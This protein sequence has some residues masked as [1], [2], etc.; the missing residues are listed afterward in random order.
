MAYTNISET[1]LHTERS[2]SH[3]HNSALHLILHPD[4]NPR[5]ASFPS[6]PDFGWRWALRLATEQDIAALY[7][8]EHLHCAESQLFRYISPY[9]YLHPEDTARYLLE[10]TLFNLAD[11]RTVVIVAEAPN[12][13]TLGNPISSSRRGTS[14]GD[15]IYSPKTN[16]VGMAVWR[17]PKDSARRGQFVVDLNVMHTM[18]SLD[19]DVDPLRHLLCSALQHAG[20]EE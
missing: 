16:V 6:Y 3:L 13:W 8:L 4:M 19:H 12:P 15:I 5:A 17:L 18:H 9:Q 7:G 2:T 1:A 10:L 14:N 20:C 11:P